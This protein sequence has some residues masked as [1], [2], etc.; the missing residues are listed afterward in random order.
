MSE[1]KLFRAVI[2][3]ALLDATKQ[4][5]DLEKREAH[6]WFVSSSDFDYVCDLAELNPQTTQ[7]RALRVIE[8]PVTVTNFVRKRLN[9][10]LRYQTSFQYS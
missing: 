5:D 2:Y 6:A 10:L 3:Q 1:T 9:V 4:D 8:Q 7:I